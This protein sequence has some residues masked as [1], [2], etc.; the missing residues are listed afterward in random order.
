[1][2]Y[3]PNWNQIKFSNESYGLIGI[4]GRSDWNKELNKVGPLYFFKK[5]IYFIEN[6]IQG[7]ILVAGDY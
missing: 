3:V 2:N 7:E 1:M 5:S 6:F 4:Q